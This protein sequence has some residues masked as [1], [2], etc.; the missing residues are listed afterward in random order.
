M[1]ELEKQVF[2]N[3]INQAR[4]KYAVDINKIET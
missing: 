3:H 1:L 2:D 4:A